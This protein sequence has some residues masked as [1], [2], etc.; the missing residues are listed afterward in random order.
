MMYMDI[1]KMLTLYIRAVYVAVRQVIQIDLR[2]LYA[3]Q[4]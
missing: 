3:M 1:S 4:R 2:S